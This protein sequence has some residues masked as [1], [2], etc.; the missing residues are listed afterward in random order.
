MMTEIRT[1]SSLDPAAGQAQK[2]QTTTTE[3]TLG[4]ACLPETGV[5]TDKISLLLG[6]NI[7]LLPCTHLNV[8]FM[9]KNM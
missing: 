1:T 7:N 4:P 3:A 6:E 8:V 9:Q 2:T 5:E